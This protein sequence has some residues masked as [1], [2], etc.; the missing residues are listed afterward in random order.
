[1][2]YYILLF[3]TYLYKL[4]G[5]NFIKTFT[6]KWLKKEAIKLKED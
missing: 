5:W 4:T 2:R 3:L 6:I 1:M